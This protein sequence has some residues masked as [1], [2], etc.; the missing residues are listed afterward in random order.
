M[1][2][3]GLGTTARDRLVYFLGR[4]END[5]KRLLARMDER[6]WRKD[7]AAYLAVAEAVGAIGKAKLGVL[8]PAQ[9]QEAASGEADRIPGVT[10]PAE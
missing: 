8:V 3:S 6:G 4:R 2:A 5:F 10:G 7:D 1:N 9:E